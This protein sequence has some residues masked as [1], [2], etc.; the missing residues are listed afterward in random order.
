MSSTVATRVDERG[1]RS[2]DVAMSA[3]LVAGL[4]DTVAARGSH[5][6]YVTVSGQVTWDELAAEVDALARRLVGAGVTAG[7]RVAVLAGN[8]LPFTTAVFATWRLGAIAVPLNYRLTAADLGALLADS[9]PALLLVG[10]GMGDLA[11]AATSDQGD[12]PVIDHADASGRFL[13]GAVEGDLRRTH[14][15]PTHR[16]RSCTPPVRRVGRRAS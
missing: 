4:R 15:E 11:A 7:D 2:Y 6:A 10:S 8:G 12:G 5:P 9:R 1:V 14:R 13:D 16:P 3:D